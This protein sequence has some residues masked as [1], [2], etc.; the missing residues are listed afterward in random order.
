[1]T[2]VNTRVGI[3]GNRPTV[4]RDENSLHVDGRSRRKHR[5]KEPVRAELP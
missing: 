2:L 5:G 1:M 4:N 3:Q